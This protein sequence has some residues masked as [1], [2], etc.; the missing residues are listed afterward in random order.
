MRSIFSFISA[1]LVISSLAVPV[2][3]EEMYLC[4]WRNPERTMVRLFPEAKDYRTITKKID[5]DSLKAIE[6]RAGRLLP[7]QRDLFQYFELTGP[8]GALLG[9]VFAGSQKGEYGAIEF[10]SG[11]DKESR[12]K[13]VYI[14]RSREKES[15]FKSREFLDQFKGLAADKVG[16]L[17]LVKDIAV[18]KKTAG[19][20][21]VLAGIKK[22]LTAFTVLVSSR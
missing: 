10:V 2:R 5:P 21:A 17:E 12:I 14:Q 4:I 3:S 8:D 9:Y 13:G 11:L 19:A 6:A 7:G 22:E 20:Q 15:E 1:L 16:A 18:K